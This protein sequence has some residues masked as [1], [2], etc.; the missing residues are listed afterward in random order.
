[1]VDGRAVLGRGIL[2]RLSVL[3][4]SGKMLDFL[5]YLGKGNVAIIIHRR[6]VPTS[7]GVE[8]VE[9]FILGVDG[10][11]YFDLIGPEVFYAEEQT[12]FGLPLRVEDDFT[13]LGYEQVYELHHVVMRED[14]FDQ[15]TYRLSRAGHVG[16]SD[17]YSFDPEAERRATRRFQ[18]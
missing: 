4:E 1:M 17:V 12:E 16:Y 6:Q 14:F 2:S 9:R 10:T 11:L 3:R 8:S 7:D 5:L 18:G 13:K 15:L